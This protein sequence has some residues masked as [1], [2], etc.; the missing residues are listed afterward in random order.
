MIHGPFVNWHSVWN[1]TRHHTNPPAAMPALLTPT[2][3]PST[4]YIELLAGYIV[5]TV[6][7]DAMARFD[8]LFEHTS[9]TDAERRAF[10]RFYL[11]TVEIGEEADAMPKPSE[12]PGILA[13]ARA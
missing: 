7:D 4:A 13:A 10:A 2:T 3:A 6:G 11:D 1:E 8:D 5:G 12:V 9:A